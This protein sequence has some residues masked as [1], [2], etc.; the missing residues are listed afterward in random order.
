[1]KDGA[2]LRYMGYGQGIDIKEIKIEFSFRKGDIM[3]I[4]F[5]DERFDVITSLEVLEHVPDIQKALSET[6]RVL[7]KGGLFVMST[8][9]NH[10]FFRVFWWFWEKTF[11]TMW[12]D[13]HVI[14][15]PKKDWVNLLNRYFKIEK[16]INYWGVNLI[17]KMRK[18]E[19]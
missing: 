10:L 9:N 11:G 17:I 12:R 6:R 5:K 18:L 3:D 15:I 7:K 4:P 19:K 14:N 8:P 13:K 2:F 16:I 1:M